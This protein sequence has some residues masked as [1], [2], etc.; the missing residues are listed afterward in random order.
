M[1]VIVPERG[2]LCATVPADGGPVP[3]NRR[4]TAWCY[5]Q[6]YRR[7]FGAGAQAKSGLVALVRNKAP[8]H[9]GQTYGGALALPWAGQEAR[10]TW[11][12][13]ANRRPIDNRPAGCQPAP[14][15]RIR[16]FGRGLSPGAGLRLR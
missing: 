12:P 1:L 2:S 11:R 6:G 3:P 5:I 4:H 15:V 16:G 7:P 8:V 10:P 9:G 14:Q 13:A